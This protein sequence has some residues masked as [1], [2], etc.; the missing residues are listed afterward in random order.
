MYLTLNFV[1]CVFEQ[2]IREYFNKHAKFSSLMWSTAV[3]I[4]A[5]G[6]MFGALIGPIIANSLGR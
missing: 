4:F 5:V 1:V 3:A 6:G 2:N